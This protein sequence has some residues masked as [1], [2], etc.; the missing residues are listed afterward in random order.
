MVA[1]STHRSSPVDS[2]G[3]QTARRTRTAGCGADPVALTAIDR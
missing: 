3:R 2:S 1:K